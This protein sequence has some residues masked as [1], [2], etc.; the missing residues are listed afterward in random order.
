LKDAGMIYFDE[1]VETISIPVIKKWL[2]LHV[3]SGK[4]KKIILSPQN[5]FPMN[6]LGLTTLQCFLIILS[7]LENSLRAGRK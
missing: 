6:F 4:E 1:A 2:V 3:I 7:R 5:S